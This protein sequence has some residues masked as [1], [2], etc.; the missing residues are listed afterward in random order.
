MPKARRREELIRLFHELAPIARTFG[1]RLEF[2]ED[3]TAVVTLP[4]NPALNNGRQ[5]IHGGVYATILDSAGWFASAVCRSDYSWIATSEMS[6]HFM[7]PCHATELRGEGRI[8]KKGKR[9]DVAEMRLFD[10]AGE[11]VGHA[12]GTF[13]VLP[14]L[15][16]DTQRGAGG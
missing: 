8:L 14:H 5:G 16:L 6:I 13:L 12:V 7:K 11:L 1:M 15:E 10:G 9:Q 4:Y 3:D 2:R